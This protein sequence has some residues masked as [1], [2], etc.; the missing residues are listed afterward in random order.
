M[1]K[2]HYHIWPHGVNCDL[3]VCFDFDW[4]SQSEYR[5]LHYD[6][7]QVLNVKLIGI[8]ELGTACNIL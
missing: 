6:H 7:R 5:I 3:E 2:H 1:L 8:R 4:E